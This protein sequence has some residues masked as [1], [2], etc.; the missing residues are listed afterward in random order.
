M[1][2]RREPVNINALVR[3]VVNDMQEEMG[4]C[5]IAV[6]HDL[7]SNLG[8]VL[9]HQLHLEKVLVNLLR[10]SVEAIRGSQCAEGTIHVT[11]APQEAGAL[12]TVHDNGPGFTPEQT[13]RILEPFYTSKVTGVGMGL[14]VSRA[15]VETHGG[16]LWA[17][18]GAGATVR[19]TVPFA[20]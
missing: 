20:S 4:A 14:P 5:N 13:A 2:V 17:E 11:T 18:A 10:N 12:V 9:S 16:K 15:L 19:F 3:Q 8:P 6:T 1:H 7:C